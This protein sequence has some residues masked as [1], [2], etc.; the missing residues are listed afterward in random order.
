MSTALVSIVIFKYLLL[1]MRF[2]FCFRLHDG[3]VIPHCS[4]C[5]GQKYPFLFFTR[6][7]TLV[8]SIFIFTHL[9]TFVPFII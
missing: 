1:S 5:F 8:N 6:N 3:A 7:I 2:I 9:K 4:W